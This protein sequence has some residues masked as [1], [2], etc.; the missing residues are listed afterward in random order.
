MRVP[1]P[2]YMREV[3]SSVLPVTTVVSI[4]YL[5]QGDHR[6]TVPVQPHPLYSADHPVRPGRGVQDGQ[7]Q[8]GPQLGGPV[9]VQRLLDEVRRR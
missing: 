4:G 8:P 9:A 2:M 7:V 6:H 5:P 3:P 1:M